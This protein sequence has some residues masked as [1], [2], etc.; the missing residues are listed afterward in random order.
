MDLTHAFFIPGPGLAGPVLEPTR[1][2]RS[3]TEG[4]PT[5]CS[6]DPEPVELAGRHDHQAPAVLPGLARCGLLSRGPR[7]VLGGAQPPPCGTDRHRSR[8]RGDL[9]GRSLDGSDPVREPIVPV[10]TAR[11]DRG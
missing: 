3:R 5:V 1:Y 8:P 7:Q 4:C 10:E 2:P 6:R 9:R 11:S